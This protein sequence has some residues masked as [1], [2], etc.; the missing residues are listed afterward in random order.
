MLYVPQA[1][2]H[3]MTADARGTAGPAKDAAST[4]G[5]VRTGG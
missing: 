4:V 1:G 2:G 5:A 3:E